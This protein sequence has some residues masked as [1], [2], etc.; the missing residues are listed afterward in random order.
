M[1][2]VIT[3]QTTGTDSLFRRPT[4]ASQQTFSLVGHALQI[5]LEDITEHHMFN[6]VVPLLVGI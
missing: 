2:G 5:L 1:P 3:S 4:H 6:I